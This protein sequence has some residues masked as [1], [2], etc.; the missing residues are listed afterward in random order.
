MAG[1]AQLGVRQ[2]HKLEIPRFNSESR[3]QIQE[4]LC[5]W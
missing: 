5:M 4:Q 3:Y 1:V 2:S